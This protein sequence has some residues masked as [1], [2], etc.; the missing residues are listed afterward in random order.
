MKSLVLSLVVGL[1]ASSAMAATGNL[2]VK[3]HVDA[4]CKVNGTLVKNGDTL[5]NL[6][7]D[8]GPYDALTEATAQATEGNIGLSVACTKGVSATLNLDNGSYFSNGKRR[9]IQTTDAGGQAVVANTADFLEYMLYQPAA[10]GSASFTNEWLSTTLFPLNTS[11]TAP[12]TYTIAGKLPAGQ[13]VSAGDYKDI[14]RI[15]LT[16]N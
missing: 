15:T 4:A 7:L 3:A 2:N 9:M 13:N 12:K 6:T 14:V 11:S 8:F 1:M 10:D 5:P 16:I